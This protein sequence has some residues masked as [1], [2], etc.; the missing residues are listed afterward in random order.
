MRKN[1]RPRTRA[2]VTPRHV[3]RHHRQ[4][5]HGQPDIL[6]P[7]IDPGHPQ[8]EEIQRHDHDGRDLQTHPV[9]Y[10]YGHLCAMLV[11]IYVLKRRESSGCSAGSAAAASSDF[12][13]RLAGRG[14]DEAVVIVSTVEMTTTTDPSPADADGGSPFDELPP[15]T[16]IPDVA[17]LHSVRTE[18]WE[19]PGDIY[20][21]RGRTAPTLPRL[22]QDRDIGSAHTEERRRQ[23]VRDHRTSPA[24]DGTYVRPRPRASTPRQDGEGTTE[25]RI[26]PIAGE[27]QMPRSRMTR[28]R[29]SLRESLR[30]LNDSQKKALLEIT[31][32]KR[33]RC[34]PFPG[35]RRRR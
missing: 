34:P 16:S 25:A 33:E 27:R 19:V 22:G 11:Y 9:L 10:Y 13:R 31:T 6:A 30:M 3:Q 32:D 35:R 29:E 28:E 5:V 14:E 2:T 4:A 12:H 7:E 17:V 20:P 18:T 15:G 1:G 24:Q 8:E 26:E 21:R 23:L